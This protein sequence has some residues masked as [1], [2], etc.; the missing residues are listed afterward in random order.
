MIFNLI[1]CITV[2]LVV[3]LLS[4]F[5]FKSKN[6]KLFMLLNTVLLSLGIILCVATFI[7]YITASASIQDA[8]ARSWFTDS[9]RMYLIV[10]YIIVAIL[11]VINL[12]TVFLTSKKNKNFKLMNYM[13]AFYSPISSVFMLLFT[14]YGVL[15][16][17]NQISTFI[18]FTLTA[19]GQALLIRLSNLIYLV[20]KNGD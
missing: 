2:A 9:I 3:I 16:E 12:I 5:E 17:N 6:R 13:R 11:L 20:K 8:S 15:V 10:T 14:I 7:S 18:Y 19:A 1:I 4:F